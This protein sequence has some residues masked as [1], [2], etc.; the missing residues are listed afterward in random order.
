MR[1][2]QVCHGAEIP[3]VFQPNLTA[4]VGSATPVSF[5]PGEAQLAG[6]FTTYVGNFVR[7]GAPGAAPAPTAGTGKGDRGAL[8]V[9]P[10]PAG[11][12]LQWPAFSAAKPSVLRLGAGE[13]CG[14]LVSTAPQAGAA[15]CGFW[16]GIGYNWA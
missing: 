8:H 13:A 14:T 3:Y 12:P 15:S 1:A 11:P 10:P 4:A 9:A 2:P 5:T 6:A 16:T 7:T